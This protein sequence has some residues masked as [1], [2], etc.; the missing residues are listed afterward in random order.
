LTAAALAFSVLLGA[1]VGQLD[2]EAGAYNPRLTFPVDPEEYEVGPGDVL[3]IAARGGL[4]TQFSD[5]AA[6][7]GLRLPVTPDGYVVVPLLG[8]FDTHGMTLSELAGEIESSFRARFRGTEPLVGLAVLRTFRISVTGN[9]VRPG[10][11]NASAANRVEDLVSAAGG[12]AHGGSWDRALLMRDGDSLEVDLAGYLESGDWEANPMLT[13]GDRIHVPAA[14]AKVGI[15]GAVSLRRIYETGT[16]MAQADTSW[17]GSAR[18]FLTYV[19]GE[20]ASGLLERAGGLAPWAYPNR[21]YVVRR[22]SS[23]REERL[24]APMDDPSADPLMMPSDMLV[25]PGAPVTVMVAGHVVDPGPKS[26]VPG[27]DAGYYIASAGGADDEADLRETEIVTPDGE[28]YGIDEMRSIPSGSVI[29]VPRAELVW[30]QD[31][32]TVATGI[33]SVVIAWKSIF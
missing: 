15:E 2:I 24:P 10:L 9:V 13:A 21:C 7:G 3:W 28:S 19:E 31:Y 22:D 17:E 6:R 30:W 20:T 18:G 33:A 1:A 8:A 14:G 5:S 11:Y 12:V 16:Q 27:M 32:L 26:Y 23:G 25:C 29:R 4:P